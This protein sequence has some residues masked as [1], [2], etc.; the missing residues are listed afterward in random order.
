M[1][2]EQRAFDIARRIARRRSAPALHPSGLNCAGVL[3][4]PGSD[5]GRWGG[6][7]LDRPGL[8]DVAVRWSRAAGLPGGLPDGLGLALRVADAGGPGAPL[9][10]LLT[11]SGAGRL[12]RH[13]P[14]PRRDAIGGPYSTLVSYR[15]GDRER[16]LAAFPVRHGPRRV[17]GGLPALR[18]ALG[19]APV[20]FDLRA[21]AP[22]E[23]WRSFATLTVR[24]PGDAPP[25]SSPGYDP[26]AHSVPGL[27]PTARLRDLRIA[28][29]SGSRH[30]RADRAGAR[31]G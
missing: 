26:Y 3:D 31:H 10:L 12:G 13:L 4:V 5:N 7:W 9:D 22:G 18:E 8:Y 21:A 17:P 16:V 23:P 30:G 27:R 19:R 24:A 29:Y 14:L 20:S 15:A 6:G 1:L 11:S 28:A 25:T 2:L